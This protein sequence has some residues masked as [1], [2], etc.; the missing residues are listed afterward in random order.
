MELDVGQPLLLPPGEGEIIGDSTDRRVE[1]LSDHE[2]LNA[3]WSRFGPE[4]EGADP[5]IHRRHSDLFYVLAGEL[6]VGLGADCGEI[7]APAGTLVLA[8]PLVVHSFR[9]GSTEE[10][11]Y[12]NLHAPGKG[13]ADYLRGR[14][15]GREASFDSEDPPAD[16]G[17]PVDEAIVRRGVTLLADI[18]EIGV[19]EVRSEPDSASPPQHFHRR[20][21]EF[22]YVLAGELTF[23]TGGRELRATPGSWVQI[24]P[25]VLHTFAVTVAEAARFLDIHAPS[26]GLGELDQEPA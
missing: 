11:R 8:P 16:G 9:N 6:T 7:V 13:F 5:H 19:T 3:T 1:I 25:G 15:D 26:C 17:R 22:F 21:S 14:R 20:H 10:V 23:T 4:R 24:P 12:L 18:E 2:A